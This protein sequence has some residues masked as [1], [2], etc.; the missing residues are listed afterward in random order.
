MAFVIVFYHLNQLKEV[1][2]EQRDQAG[3]EHLPSTELN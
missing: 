2:Q 1:T 3:I